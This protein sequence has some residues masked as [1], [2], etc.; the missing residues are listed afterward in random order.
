MALTDCIYESNHESHHENNGI[1]QN[2]PLSPVPGDRND[3][4]DMSLH[5]EVVSV[6]SSVGTQE[7]LK[8]FILTT[9]SEV[10]VT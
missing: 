3:H 7:T 4:T 8:S 5:M 2:R 6:D 10:V 1:L 9:V